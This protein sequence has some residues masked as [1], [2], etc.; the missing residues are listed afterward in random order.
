VL[1]QLFSDRF[2]S[3]GKLKLKI[4]RVELDPVVRLGFQFKPVYFSLDESE[5]NFLRFR[6]IER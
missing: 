4:V 2:E 1:S 3:L 5:N 6:I